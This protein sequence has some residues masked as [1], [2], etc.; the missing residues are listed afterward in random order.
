MSLRPPPAEKLSNRSPRG[1]VDRAGSR[2]R[3]RGWAGAAL[4]AAWLALLV[5]SSPGWLPAVRVSPGAEGKGNPYAALLGYTYSSGTLELRLYRGFAHP[6]AQV[7]VRVTTPSGALSYVRQ[8]VP[9]SREFTVSFH[10]E[11]PE[12]LIEVYVGGQLALR[13][14]LAL[15]G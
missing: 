2:L 5:A 1:P 3:R 9:P 4:Y 8:R 13:T 15:T 12:A 7:E 11:E 14:T 10:V 6:F